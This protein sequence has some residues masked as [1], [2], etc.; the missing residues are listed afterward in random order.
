LSRLV[1][2]GACPL[3]V[4]GTARAQALPQTKLAAVRSLRCVFSAAANGIWQ[5]GEAT[6]RLRTGVTLKLELDAIDTQDGT[7]VLLAAPESDSHLVA[8]LSGWTLHFVQT[9]P[10]GRLTV[11]SVFARESR[12]G[13]LKAMHSRSSYIPA[14]TQ[15]NV[16]EPEAQQYYGE[17][18]AAY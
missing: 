1:L 15:G 7:A 6:V 4:C 11:T 9:S 18:E 12:D 5:G 3:L 16:A 2:L 8:Q 14:G 10:T 17:C 13:K